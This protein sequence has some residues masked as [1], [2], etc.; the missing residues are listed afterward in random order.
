MPRS[1]EVGVGRPRAGGREGKGCSS[2]RTCTGPASVGGVGVPGGQAAAGVGALEVD[3]LG[4]RR[5]VVLQAVRTLVPICRE[6]S[7]GRSW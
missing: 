5:A 6:D 2:G 7:E 4:G 3:A 1:L